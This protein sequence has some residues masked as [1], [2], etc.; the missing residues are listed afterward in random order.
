MKI[1][2]KIIISVQNRL[3][4][5]GWWIWLKR[6]V[7]GRVKLRGNL[8][9]LS[10][11]PTFHC[12]GDLW[13]GIYSHEGNIVI[14]SDVRASGPLVITA[15]RRVTLGA[16]VLL[17]P[18]VMITDHYHG[19]PKDEN[20]FNLSPSSRSLHT[21]GPIDIEDD[22]QIGANTAILSPA[23]I[24]RAAILGAN[25]VANGVIESRKI[26][27]GLPARPLKT[28]ISPLQKNE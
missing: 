28:I 4:W 7:N 15:I 26:Y 16:G 23:H 24:G 3:Q 5:L 14:G 9:G 2:Q 18:N 12:D 25:S 21:R 19:D 22:V 17:G 1:L 8:G 27:A 11:A 20:I 13:L 10:I 6:R